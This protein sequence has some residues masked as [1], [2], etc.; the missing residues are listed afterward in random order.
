MVCL[1]QR[2][3]TDKCIFIK[4]K[5]NLLIEYF[6]LSLWQ[7]RRPRKLTYMIWQMAFFLCRLIVYIYKDMGCSIPVLLFANRCE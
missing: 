2:Q 3:T 5:N 7:F 4:S 1:E 6:E